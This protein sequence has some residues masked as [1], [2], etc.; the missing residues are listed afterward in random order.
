MART[1]R[2]LLPHELNV[3]LPSTDEY[4][5]GRVVTLQAGLNEVDDEMAKHPIVRRLLVGED[6]TQEGQAK[7][8]EA[9][10]RRDEKIQAAWQEYHNEYAKINEEWAEKRAKRTADWEKDR[11]EATNEGVVFTEPH[12][13][14]ETA[15]A[16]ALTGLPHRYAAT[17]MVTKEGDPKSATDQPPPQRRSTSS[18]SDDKGGGAGDNKGGAGAKK[19]D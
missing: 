1:Q 10:R 18:S 19:A 5:G 6:E 13:D 17:A 14:E 2:A 8:A 15:R 16:Q 7:A 4:P 12:P 3:Q 11:D 9:A